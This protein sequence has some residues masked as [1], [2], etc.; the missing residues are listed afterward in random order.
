VTDEHPLDELAV[1]ALDALDDVERLVVEAHLTR[2]PACATVVD[3]H[4]A[5]LAA[6]TADE[7]PP[8]AVWQ[9]IAAQTGAG[10][11]P[12][13]LAVMPS[14]P[15]TPAA[16]GP[17]QPP[18]PPPARLGGGSGLG[19]PAPPTHLGPRG[20]RG[21]RGSRTAGRSAPPRR[22]VAISGVAAAAALVVGGVA[23]VAASRDD[24]PANL[25]DL[26]A[27][28]L[29]QPGASVATLA[30]DD[31]RD[32]AR[33]VADGSTGYIV[34]DDLPTLPAGQAYQLWRLGGDAPVSL[35]VIGD[36]REHVATVGIPTGTDMLAL[37]TEPADGSVAPTG[38]IVATGRF[39]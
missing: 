14:T 24:E 31:G 36:G 17:S 28:A 16:P 33:V 1:Y 12:T 26:A 10:D 25:A 7:P 37:S 29:E 4:R 19:D 38:A 9:R 35:G 34:L 8:P 11:V 23:G 2:C 21:S 5:T 32:A 6:L 22:W 30:T 20:A 13:P 15:S 18:P 27:A 39:A 3:E